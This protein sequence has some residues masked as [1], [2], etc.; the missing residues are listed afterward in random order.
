MT[1]S[2]EDKGFHLLLIPKMGF[3]LYKMIFSDFLSSF[4]GFWPFW[5]D[6]GPF[7]TPDL[8]EKFGSCYP[9]QAYIN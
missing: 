4:D 1:R 7:F 6:I 9:P 8:R 3:K 2:M 5:G